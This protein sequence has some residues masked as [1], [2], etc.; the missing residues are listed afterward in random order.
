MLPRL[1]IAVA[2]TA[3]TASPLF[4]QDNAPIQRW[5]TRESAPAASQPAPAPAPQQRVAV[6]RQP[7]PPP[8]TAAPAPQ[9]S[10]PQERVAGQRR[11]PPRDG[12]GERVAVP[13]RGPAPSA[14]DRDRDRRDRDR[15][16]VYIA[17]RPLPYGYY[18]YRRDYYPYGYGAFGGLGYF[19][20]DPF[21]WS[22]RAPIYAYPSGAYGR[23]YYGRGYNYDI[24]EVRLRVT[25]RDAQ[26][27]VDG[28][29][30]G[31]V[32]NYDGILQGLRLESGPYHIEV[33]APGYETAQ[34]DI[35]INPGQKITY[36]ADLRRLP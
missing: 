23:G 17:P 21:T 10:Q 9:P 35:R 8:A 33:R 28:Y 14:R 5:P 29:F 1:L 34:F 36:R 18:S 16:N 4:A 31:E 30:A 15:T 6:P 20:Y 3:I 27:F 7:S 24:G 2:V 22:G 13:R 26:V 12:S 32:D 19:Y 11:T 25:P